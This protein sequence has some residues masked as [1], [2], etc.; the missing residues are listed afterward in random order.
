[1]PGDPAS[2][3]GQPDDGSSQSEHVVF[4]DGDDDP[5]NPSNWPRSR[6]W[7]HVALISLLAFLSPLATTMFAPAIQH[8]MDDFNSSSQVLS[9]LIV[10]IYVLGWVLGPLVLAPL[11]EIHGRLLIYHCSGMVYIAFTVCCALSPRIEV[12]IM[13]RFLAGAAGSAPLAIG[14]GT[15]SDLVPIERRGMAL[16]LYMFG[17]ILGPSIGPLLGGVLTDNLS[18]RHIFWVIGAAYLFVTVIQILFM[19]ET[20]P[21]AIL[22]AKTR[23]LR[24]STGNHALRSGLDP[25]LT[26]AQALARAAIRPAR[27]TLL[28]PASAT[29]A[30]ISAYVNGLLFLLLTSSPLLLQVEYGLSPRAIGLTFIAYGLG[31]LVGLASFNLFSDRFVRARAAKGA[32]RAEHRLASALV[33]GPVLAAGFLWYGWSAQAHAPLLV[34]VAGTALIGAAGV[35]FTSGVIAYLI[36]CS[37]EYAAS[38]V[39]ANTVVRSIGGALLPLAARDMYRVLGWGWGSTVLAAGA[40]LFTPALV[41][42][43][44]RGEKIRNNKPALLL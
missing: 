23:R 20:Y 17:P 33:S 40:A 13:A 42:L 10:T 22:A 4:W 35:L 44:V 5:A 14:G 28:S 21:A 31:N 43:Y 34:P 27:L 12:L 7:A 11:S 18:W 38:A 36:D 41:Y 30:F 32:L 15:I 1:M 3:L 8:V 9:S 6:A 19:R 25:G 29:L 37:T 26:D 2:P 24:K 16:S 39:A